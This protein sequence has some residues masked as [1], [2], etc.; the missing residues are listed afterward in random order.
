LAYLWD[1]ETLYG[2][3]FAYLF[4]AR[5]HDDLRELGRYFWMARGEPL[6]KAQKELIF[7]FWDRC[8][9]WSKT[10]DSPPASLLSQL[11]LLSCYLTVIDDR[12]LGWLL[13]VAPH[14]PVNHNVDRFVEELSRL[15]PAN[16]AEAGQILRT[17]LATYEPSHD[18]EDRLKRLIT[19]LA[20]HPGSRSDAILSAERVRH[21]PGM[22]QLYGQITSTPGSARV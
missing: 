6:T 22:V 4:E 1:Q 16:P 7:L 19:L 8:V 10:L 18:F 9:A 14:T 11:S 5:R 12:A 2:L 15:A 13:A 17:L 20:A 21:L 3:R